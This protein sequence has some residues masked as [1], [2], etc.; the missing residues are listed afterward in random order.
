MPKI[1]SHSSAKKRFKVTGSGKVRRPGA[2]TSHLMR[3][4]SKKAKKVNRGYSIV[5]DANLPRVERML[6]LR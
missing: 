3:S 6:Q 4:K 5:N 1:K 2:N